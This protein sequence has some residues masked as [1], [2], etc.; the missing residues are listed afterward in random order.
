MRDGQDMFDAYQEFQLSES[1]RQQVGWRDQDEDG[2]YDVVDTLS[3]AFTGI[4]PGPGLPDAAPGRISTSTT[5]PRCPPVSPIRSGR[6]GVFM[7]GTPKQT[8]GWAHYTDISLYTPVNINRPSFVVGARQWRRPGS[9]GAPSDGAWDEELEAYTIS[10]LGE[11]GVV[12]QVE[13]AIMDRWGRSATMSDP[14]VDV[15]VA[16][17]A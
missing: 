10:L 3:D 5:S 16:H 15:T 9:Q 2:V 13:V 4:D 17:A 1:A 14:P 8:T 12:N 7:S 11:A 6:S